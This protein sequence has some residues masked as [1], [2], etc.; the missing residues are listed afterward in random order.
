[1]NTSATIVIQTISLMFGTGAVALMLI[2]VMRR[3]TEWQI[4][5]APIFM[6]GMLTLFLLQRILFKSFGWFELPTGWVNSWAV[7]IQLMLTAA[8]FVALAVLLIF[9]RVNGH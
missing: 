9:R 3:S 8:A 5:I 1:M 4:L 2:A 6:Y 7:L